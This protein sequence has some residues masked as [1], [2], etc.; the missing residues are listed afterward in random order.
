MIIQ[1]QVEITLISNQTY[2]AVEYWT[3]KGYTNLRPQQKL[4]VKVLDLPSFSSA[5]VLFKCD[6]CGIEWK[7]RY[8]KKHAQRNYE[9]DLC[10]KCARLNVGKRV[11][12]NNAIKAGKKNCGSNHHNWNPNKSEFRAYAY[13]VRR[14]SEKTYT[15]H[16]SILNPNG[17]QRTLCGTDGGYQLDH[18]VS[19]KAAFDLRMPEENVAQVENLQLL[20]WKDNRRKTH[21]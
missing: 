17:L 16:L 9:K 6:E 15:E 18:K 1:E 4:T 5:S 12:R 20:P 19:I 10:N 8:S 3:E 11:A 2:D 13:K 21:K 7:R 14:L